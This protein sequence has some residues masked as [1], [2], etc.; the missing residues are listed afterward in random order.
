VERAIERRH[1]QDCAAG[2]FLV[3]FTD[4][5]LANSFLKHD[6]GHSYGLLVDLQWVLTALPYGHGIAINVG[7]SDTMFEWNADGI[8]A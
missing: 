8:A 5:D 6:P 4:S 7:G 1:A 3:E 2:Q